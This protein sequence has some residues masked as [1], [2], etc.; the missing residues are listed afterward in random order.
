MKNKSWYWRF[1]P[2]KHTS[3]PSFLTIFYL[4]TGD[5]ELAA[6]LTEEIENETKARLHPDLPQLDDFIP[7]LN[8]AEVTLTR[9]LDNEV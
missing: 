8:G 5:Q 3:I 9:K 6:Y 4:F 2:A 7:E 1:A